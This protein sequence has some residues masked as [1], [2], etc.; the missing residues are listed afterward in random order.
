MN[1]NVKGSANSTT[2]ALSITIII[3]YYAIVFRR[4]AIYS[5]HPR[6]AI[7]DARFIPAQTAEQCSVVLPCC[8]NILYIHYYIHTYGYTLALLSIRHTTISALGTHTVRLCVTRIRERP[9]RN[10]RVSI[11][12]N[13]CSPVCESPADSGPFSRITS[14]TEYAARTRRT[15]CHTQYET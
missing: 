15:L 4:C 10:P 7:D 8:L 6:Q 12:M 14:L 1:I 5:D 2:A 11:L 13:M 9:L 3:S